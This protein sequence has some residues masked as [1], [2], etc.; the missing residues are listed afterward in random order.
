MNR[1]LSVFTFTLFAHDYYI[2]YL[3]YTD[4]VQ[5]NAAKSELFDGFFQY[6]LLKDFKNRKI[7]IAP[8]IRLYGTDSDGY[9]CC[10]HVHGVKNK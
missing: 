3:P 9:K 4:N 6:R 10:V 8:I 7:K 2:M 5:C 1:D